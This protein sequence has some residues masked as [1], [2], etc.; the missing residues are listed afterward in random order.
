VIAGYQAEVERL[1]IDATAQLLLERAD[2]NGN[3]LIRQTN[4]RLGATINDPDIYRVDPDTGAPTFYN[5]DT[6]RPFTGDNPRAQAKEWVENYNEDLREAFNQIAAQ[7]RAQLDQEYEPMIRLLRFTPKYDALDTVRQK[8]L[9][10]L[11][12]DYEV[13]G[14]DGK[15]IGYSV[16][17]DKALE[18]VNRQ[19]AA[20]KTDQDTAS[21]AAAEPPKPVVQPAL[22]MRTNS[23]SGTPGRE[24]RSLAEAM[25]AE[26]D[27]ILEKSRKK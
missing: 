5:P 7:Q 20:L 21:R 4:G 23:G 8:M 15:A 18:Q 19:V 1:A 2:A 27:A 17:L 14:A 26:Q 6:G 10:A 12:E 11:I 13:L 25:E 22:D 3:R 16:D 24:I 9:D